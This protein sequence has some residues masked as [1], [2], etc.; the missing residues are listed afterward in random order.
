MPTSSRSGGPAGRP[1]AWASPPGPPPD[2]GCSTS[3]WPT[4]SAATRPSPTSWPPTGRC[5]TPSRWSRAASGRHLYFAWPDGSG[6]PQRPGG[7][8]RARARRPRRGRP[9]PRP[10][11]RAPQRHAVRLGGL[12]RPLRRHRRG[13]GAGVARR[14]STR[15]PR[16]RLPGP[17]VHP[18][19]RAPPGRRLRRRGDLARAADGQRGRR[20]SGNGSTTEPVPATI[21]ARPGADHT[22]AT[23]YYGG[24]DLLKVHSATGRTSARGRPTRASAS[25]WRPATAATSPAP[26]PSCARP[27]GRRRPR[28]LGG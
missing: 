24:T 14:A 3:T 13:A 15:A 18:H 20:S 28:R 11:H 5:P 22:S 23:L 21:W 9:G 27:P 6:R 19:R 25:S 26:P 16:R 1:T 4:A 2:C 7:P 10:A 12:R 8:A 17:S